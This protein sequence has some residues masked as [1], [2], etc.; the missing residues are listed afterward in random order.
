MK[1]VRV[2]T[3]DSCGLQLAHS[4]LSILGRIPKATILTEEHVNALLEVGRL[5][6]DV[7]IPDAIDVCEDI[8]A[9]RL[10]SSIF[11]KNSEARRANGGRYNLFASCAGLVNFS[12]SDIQAF[13]SIAEEITLATCLPNTPIRQYDHIATLKIIPFYVPEP[14]VSQAEAFL[15]QVSF[16]V[17]PWQTELKVGLIQTYN[18]AV[19]SKIQD[20]AF[21]IQTERLSFYGIRGLSDYRVP[22]DLEQ[23][24]N[25]VRVAY[26]TNLDLLMILG[27]SAICDRHDVIPSALQNAGGVVTYFGMPVDPG[28]LMLIGQ[29]HSTTIIGLPGC[30]RSPSLNGLDLVLDRIVAGLPVES[31]DIQRMGVGGLL[32]GRPRREFSKRDYDRSLSKTT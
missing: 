7:V 15:Q 14:K 17:E 9:D 30:A 11:L 23:L 20:K 18:A 28:N 5:E 25:C 32:V 29:L 24:T 4:Q 12:R 26:G 27:A 13:N 1:L 8:V 6:I 16:S 19:S 21:S 3:K 2:S 22:H 10:V 31:T